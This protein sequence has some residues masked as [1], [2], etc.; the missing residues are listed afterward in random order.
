MS[1]LTQQSLSVMD[2]DFSMVKVSNIVHPDSNVHNP[3]K[4]KMDKLLIDLK[5]YPNWFKSYHRMPFTN[6]YENDKHISRVLSNIMFKLFPFLQDNIISIMG[7]GEKHCHQITD[8]AFNIAFAAIESIHGTSLSLD[9]ELWQLGATGGVRII[10]LIKSDANHYTLYPL[11]I[12]C[13]HLLYPSDKYNKK[14]YKKF[15]K[16]IKP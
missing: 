15:K 4:P 9:I 2:Q 11:L 8:E 7:N 5:A 1:Y 3:K 10:G 14:D 12:D 6:R 13:N 16:E